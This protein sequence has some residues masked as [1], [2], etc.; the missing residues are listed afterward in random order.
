ML[1][2]N[3]NVFLK[4]KCEPTEYMHICRVKHVCM[5]FVVVFSKNSYLYLI[6]FYTLITCNFVIFFFTLWQHCLYNAGAF[7]FYTNVYRLSY[8]QICLN[9]QRFILE[10]PVEKILSAMHIFQR[11]DVNYIYLSCYFYTKNKSL[12]T[13]W[14]IVK[15]CTSYFLLMGAPV[16][17]MKK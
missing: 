17:T 8:G 3:K 2:L 9:V 12:I 11:E 6:W 4:R 15:V 16:F 1:L 13:C 14:W 10:T 7:K 5:N